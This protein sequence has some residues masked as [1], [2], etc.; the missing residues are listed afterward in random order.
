MVKHTTVL[1]YRLGLQSSTTT[2]T[3][4]TTPLGTTTTTTKLPTASRA[5]HRRVQG[6][7]L[8][9][10]APGQ[11]QVLQHLKLGTLRKWQ[12]RNTASKRL[13]IQDQHKRG[14]RKA[15]VDVCLQCAIPLSVDMEL[16]RATCPSCG[17][18]VVFAAYI[19]NVKEV[20]THKARH[21]TEKASNLHM[22]KF[23]EQYKQ[24]YP[25]VPVSALEALS[26]EYQKF[27][28]HDTKKVIT[29]RTAVLLRKCPE[30]ANI[31]KR[32]PDRLTKE[33]KAE[34]VPEY[35]D[36]E[37]NL[38]INQRNRLENTRQEGN[39]E[40]KTFNN[41]IYMRQLGRANNMEISRLFPHAKTNRIHLER[42]RNLEEVCLDHIVDTDA[43]NTNVRMKLLKKGNVKWQLHPST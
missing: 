43:T 12:T 34:S 11:V 19:F 28:E 8:L 7:R 24:G 35:S 20:E 36:L 6:D 9:P 39:Y 21:E 14:L 16:S 29:S 10:R 41:Q 1:K 38:L 26:I 5:T 40:A 31:F 17:H 23:T 32:A 27:H 25:T 13:K 3:P 33:L 22:Q 4:T 37:L 2:N 30:I 15:S 42:M 18:C